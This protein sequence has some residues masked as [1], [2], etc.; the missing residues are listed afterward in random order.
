MPAELYKGLPLI[1]LIAT[2]FLFLSL[3]RQ[4]ELDALKAAG[5]SLYRVSLPDPAHG[6]ASSASAP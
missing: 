5:V 6:A 4:R 3:T 1:V 2:V